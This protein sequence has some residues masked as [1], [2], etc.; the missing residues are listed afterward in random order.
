MLDGDR[1]ARLSRAALSVLLLV[2]LLVRL[3]ALGQV[4][5][6]LHHDEA[7]T[8]ADAL[9]LPGRIARGE[10]PLTFRHERGGWVEGTYVWLAAPA[11]AA[12]RAVGWPSLEAAAR[13]PAALAGA[14]LVLGA[15]LL[16]RR[17]WGAGPALAVA[18][19]LACAPWGWHFSRL[20]LRA[21][22]VPALAVFGC[23][24][25][26]CARDAESPRARRS[27]ALAGGCLL[28]LAALT[29]PP[30][31]L[32]APLLAAAFALGLG[33]SRGAAA[34][35]LAPPAVALLALLPWTLAGPGAER[36]GE[37]AI[38]TDDPPLGLTLARVARGYAVH[39]APRF[40]FAGSTSRGFAPEGVGLLPWWQAPLLVLGAIVLVRRARAGDRVAAACLVWV[41]L[42]PL[43]AAFTRDVPNA[44]RAVLG[45]PA[46]ALVAGLGLEAAVAA[47]RRRGVTVALVALGLWVAGEAVWD[48]QAYFRRYPRE[49]AAFY[50]PERR[51]LVERAAAE[52]RAGRAVLC[53]GE[54]LEASLRLYAPDVPRRGRGG[55]WVLGAGPP[56]VR[57][58]LTA[59][60]VDLTPLPGQDDAP[61]GR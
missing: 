18:V 31:R 23:W 36:L 10:A 3:A 35:A 58:T 54:F 39:L 48:G 22:L 49:E 42:F 20:A 40:L 25:L 19:C 50:R 26:S 16:T 21:T 6:A 2:T 27:S 53:E 34:A 5:P 32:Q 28:A 56:Q 37:V 13:L 45:L 29:Y 47:R 52:A 4:P 46:L 55:A 14:A 38:L 51:S 12:A 60:G 59:G 9:E 41:A 44:L 57:A 1:A 8:A 17:L 33:L 61:V 24:A 43:A 30:A 15:Y 7:A 11:L